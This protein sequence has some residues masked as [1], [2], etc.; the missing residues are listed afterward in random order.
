MVN[1]GRVAP[2]SS[3]HLE[4]ATCCTAAVHAAA[5]RKAAAASDGSQLRKR[6]RKAAGASTHRPLRSMSRRASDVRVMRPPQRR[7]R[8]RRELKSPFFFTELRFLTELQTGNR[9]ELCP[10]VL[11]GEHARATRL[12]TR[13]LESAHRHGWRPERAAAARF[14]HECLASSLATV[15]ATVSF[16]VGPTVARAPHCRCDRF[17]IAL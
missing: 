1:S 9:P 16:I 14:G 3:T 2:I 15:V 6:G 17:V 13:A 10:T 12:A 11:R 8:R 7:R 5:L 4:A